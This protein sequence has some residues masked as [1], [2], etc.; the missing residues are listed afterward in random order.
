MN[1]VIL[2]VGLLSAAV[3][4]A[5]GETF[6]WVRDNQ[7][8]KADW[9]P[10]GDSKSWAVG[11]TPTSGNPSG[12][13]P[14]ATDDFY[15]G[16]DHGW[17]TSYWM[18]LGGET[19][20]LRSVIDGDIDYAYRFLHIRNGELVFTGS[21]TNSAFHVDIR[22]NGKLTLS[23][24]SAGRLGRGS[25][26]MI[27]EVADTGTL[28]LKGA[29]DLVVGR[30]V[31]A[32][33]GVMNI[34]PV[35]F[36][37]D[38]SFSTGADSYLWNRGT[39]NL[40][41]GLAYTGA[42]NRASAEF[43][44]AQ[45][46]GALNLGGDISG[47]STRSMLALYLCGGTVN[48][49]DD[50]ALVTE[51]ASSR[52]K[53]VMTNDCDV[54]VNV[55]ANKTFDISGLVAEGNSALMKNGPGNLKLGATPPATLTV[56]EGVLTLSALAKVESFTMKAG[57]TLVF[58]G[59]GLAC[60][61]PVIEEGV[62][63]SISAADLKNGEIIFSSED[64][65]LNAALFE[66]VSAVPG[67]AGTF[68]LR[69]RSIVYEI[70]H[71]Q[72]V[73]SW[74]NEGQI[75]K[76]DLENGKYAYC[77]FTDP[78]TWAV[79]RS[80]TGTNPD[81][82]FPGENDDIYISNTYDPIFA[83]DM[84]GLTW[85]VRNY[86]KTGYAEKWGFNGIRVR[87]GTFGFTGTFESTRG[88]IVTE[89]GGKFVLGAD[90]T[91]KLGSGDA[92]FFTFVKDG[93]AVEY[94]GDICV[95]IVCADVRAGGTLTLCPKT[96]T[97]DATKFHG[98]HKPSYFENHGTLNL[99]NGLTLVSGGS[100]SNWGRFELRQ[101]EGKMV[102]GGPIV[103]KKEANVV[104]SFLVS[105][106]T[107][108]AT[109]DV[110][111]SGVYAVKAVADSEIAFDVAEGKTLDLTGMTFEANVSVVK[112]GDGVIRFGS[113]VPASLLVLEGEVA[114]AS[115]VSLG[116]SLTMSEGTTLCL[117]SKGVSA[118][119]IGGIEGASVVSGYAPQGESYMLFA[120]KNQ[121]LV[122]TVFAKLTTAG[123]TGI[124]QVGNVIVHEAPHAASVFSLKSSASQSGTN[125]DTFSDATQYQHFFDCNQWAV[126]RSAAGG[127][128]E[129]LFPGAEDDIY[130]NSNADSYRPL[131]AFDMD[132][133]NWLVRNYDKTDATERWGFN[134]FQ[135]RN[136]TFGFNGVFTSTRS[137]V[138]AQDGGRFVFGDD[139]VVMLGY[140]G[141]QCFGLVRAGGEIV[142]GGDVTYSA[143]QAR[144]EA[145]G[146]MTISPKDGILKDYRTGDAPQS[147]FDCYG[148]LSL[149]NGLKIVS[150]EAERD[151]TRISLLDGSTL[152][153][154]GRLE[155][156]AKKGQFAFTLGSATINVTNR[157]AIAGFTSC[158]MTAGAT[159][160]VNVPR[161]S[162]LNLSAMTFGAD[163]VIEKFGDGRVI[164]GTSRPTTYNNHGQQFGMTLILR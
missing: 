130:I 88:V 113:S 55:A 32:P 144:I 44:I 139:A 138:I 106:G 30:F 126:G 127:N 5:A 42:G 128:P 54:T 67:L 81:L 57:T 157:T 109:G 86:D 14:Q 34:D 35:R 115:G 82:L 10:Y 6:Y 41:H 143:Y 154:G 29:I 163:T 39:L 77:H 12:L 47:T 149:P 76:D 108:Q 162:S 84:D 91:S 110:S 37:A 21:F 137:V 156:T 147:Y 38:V 124:V 158:T 121:A 17:M 24:T 1:R 142:L 49:T 105:G 9:Q 4:S 11:T 2:L 129:K 136:G 116:D 92:E 26:F 8:D 7:R 56:E 48:V 16:L 146:K 141:A 68:K 120:S 36:G 101:A 102:L 74:K 15:Y 94:G 98:G 122:E 20:T 164:F 59:G 75:L 51:G 107:V 95:V 150:N 46:G 153:L 131:F 111:F 114:Y 40:P 103:Q 65:A 71:E 135:I 90:G 155:S 145:G 151:N 62:A 79:G 66:K 19:R 58:A 73:F 69:G 96:L 118:D 43:A 87:N 28:D 99:P 25:Q 93:G 134:G 104:A 18:D 83:M 33:G 70:P 132:G 13:V 60:A 85:L 3:M 159:A 160:T 63:V 119:S 31:V 27:A 45:L 117:Q 22:D 100:S 89:D 140:L 78:A 52:F 61:A 53:V 133:G 125:L 161:G 152:E 97:F 50:A 64:D 148:T 72:T 80:K 23:P 112:T 123:A